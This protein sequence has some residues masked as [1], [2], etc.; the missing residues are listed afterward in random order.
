MYSMM[1]RTLTKRPMVL[2]S[3]RLPAR[4][5]GLWMAAAAREGESQSEFLRKAI[6]DRA[7]RVLMAYKGEKERD[8]RST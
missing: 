6:F 8:A 5:K 7:R 2:C 3:V 1:R 4:D